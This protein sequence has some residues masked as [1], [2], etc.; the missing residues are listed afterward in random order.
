MVPPRASRPRR[1]AVLLAA[2][3]CLG[4][5]PPASAQN[6]LL[7]SSVL[8]NWYVR[9]AMSDLYLWYERIPAVNALRYPS[10]EAYLEAIRY[11]PLDATF[12]YIG[13]KAAEEAFYSDSQFIGFGLS[14][15]ARRRPMRVSAGVSRQSGGRGGPPRGDRI[16]EIDGAA[17]EE[18]VATGRYGTALGPAELGVAV[19]LCVRRDQGRPRASDHGQAPVTI[20]TVS[21]TRCTRSMAAGRLSLLPQLRAAVVRGARRGVRDGCG[22]RR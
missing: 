21:M 22:R 18:L 9:D 7:C 14:N 12:S 13:L 10:P 17:V 19:D 4:P 3:I 16:V 5:A 11:R 6:A 15:A 1:L 20:P 8:Q 2:A